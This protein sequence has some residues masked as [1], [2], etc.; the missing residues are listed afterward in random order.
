MKNY[1]PASW[2]E[3]A[4]ALANHQYE[5]WKEIQEHPEKAQM[6]Y[7]HDFRLDKNFNPVMISNATI[8]YYV[9]FFS[10]SYR[11]PIIRQRA[12]KRF[13]RLIRKYL[14]KHSKI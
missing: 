6:W 9:D 11:P 3:Q 13:G 8:A 1:R 5:T 7:A 14:D 10:C 4:R 12:A 2:S